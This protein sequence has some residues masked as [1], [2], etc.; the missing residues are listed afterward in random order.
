SA[1]QALTF[2]FIVGGLSMMLLLNLVFW[3]M[4]GAYLLRKPIA[5]ALPNSI[6]RLKVDE[7]TTLREALLHWKLYYE[8]V[9]NE[10]RFAGVTFWN[11]AGSWLKGRLTW[12]Q[13]KANVDAVDTWSLV[14]QLFYPVA[15]M[16]FV[17]NFVFIALGLVSCHRRGLGHL[18]PYALLVP[19][20]WVLI[21]LA[22]VKGFYQLFTNPFY[23]EKT[24]HGLVSQPPA[25]PPPGPPAQMPNMTPVTGA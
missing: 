7:T 15:M 13:A 17:A 23:W 2:R 6:A 19:F 22:A 24:V 3:V 14:S 12:E 11:T 9:K 5:N 25:A 4:T 1:W 10:E 8:N 16:L 20:Y 18:F 21:S